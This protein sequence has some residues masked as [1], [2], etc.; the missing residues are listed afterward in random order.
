MDKRKKLMIGLIVAIVAIALVGVGIW[1]GS[2]EK[3]EHSNGDLTNNDH[4]ENEATGENNDTSE[5]DEGVTLEDEVE[6]KKTKYVYNDHLSNYLFLGIDKREEVT[7]YDVRGGSGQS[8]AIYLV[9]YDR[10]KKTIKCLCIPRDSLV[11]IHTFAMDGTDM[12]YSTDHISIQYAFGDGKDESC[13]LVK[14][15]VSNLLYKLPIQ[16]YCAVNMDA[17]PIIGKTLGK[18]D[19]VV[20]NNSL[21]NAYPEFKE[22]TTVTITEAN[23]ETFVRYRDVTV[24]HSAI[25]RSERQK[26]YLKA[27]AKQAQAMVEQDA[28]IVAKLYENLTPYMVTNIGNDVFVKLSQ[29][30][31]D[32]NGNIQDIPGEKVVGQN[33]DE[34]HVNNDQLYELMLEMFYEK[35]LE[36]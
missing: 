4:T 28:S 22:G 11:K 7:G 3:E 5:E 34:Y 30:T 17:I 32:T 9:S 21:E 15:A 36:D 24:D 25:T 2:L 35:V 10:V 19:V 13:R 16:G 23:V 27:C 1:V 31:F 20:P 8:D 6:Y 29:A 12:G 33:F 18:V 26:V 14:E